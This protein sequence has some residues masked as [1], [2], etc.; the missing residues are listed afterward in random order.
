[1][2]ALG[3]EAPDDDLLLAMRHQLQVEARR[4]TNRDTPP[5]RSPQERALDVVREHMP[6]AEWVEGGSQAGVRGIGPT[7]P[8]C[9]VSVPAVSRWCDN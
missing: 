5:P 7:C 1:V 3:A 6:E 2:P 9:W 4:A 8:R